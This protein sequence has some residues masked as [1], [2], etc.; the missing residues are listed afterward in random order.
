MRRLDCPHES[1]VLS[2]VYTNRWPHQAGDELRDH[3]FE[4]RI[5]ADVLAVAAAF[6]AETDLARANAHVPDASI[7]WWRA[8]LRA[9]QAAE[10][11]AV[12]PITVAQAVGLAAI[13]GVGG[14][15]FGATATW[16]QNALGWIG[17]A[18]TDG[19]TLPTL[20]SAPAVPDGVR[21]MVSNYAMLFGALVVFFVL[22]SIA[23]YVA[24]RATESDA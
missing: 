8:Q 5:C 13:V 10:K 9:R 7:V 11:E 17:R 3:V 24:V 16:F 22:A 19:V 21:V 12:R 2:A 1:E 14:A 20:P 6:E 4:C 23:G 15:I 18:L